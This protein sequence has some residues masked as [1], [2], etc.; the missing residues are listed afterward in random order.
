MMAACN[1][2]TVRIY[3]CVNLSVSSPLFCVF[4][5]RRA[6]V[7]CVCPRPSGA[8]AENPEWETVVTYETGVNVH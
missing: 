8:E 2:A 1:T 3:V 6:T 7:P 4:L 5:L